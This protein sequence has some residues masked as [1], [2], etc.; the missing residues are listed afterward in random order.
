[1]GKS[2]IRLNT[3][4]VKKYLQP[5]IF[6]TNSKNSLLHHPPPSQGIP[7]CHHSCC[8]CAILE[9]IS[10]NEMG[11]LICHS[12]GCG[13]GAGTVSYSTLNPST[14]TQPVLTVYSHSR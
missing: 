8:M 11:V 7:L 12:P 10:L 4:F 1:M 6:F 9:L 14:G 5:L 13:L 2:R 3:H